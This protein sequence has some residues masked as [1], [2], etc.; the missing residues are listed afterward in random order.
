MDTPVVAA[1]IGAIATIAAAI[2]SAIALVR[3]AKASGTGGSDAVSPVAPASPLPRR[4][5]FFRGQAHR[6]LNF[7]GMHCRIEALD[8]SKSFLAPTNE[9][10]HDPAGRQRIT[11]DSIVER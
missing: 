5:V 4:M 7:G 9:L 10:F 3:R 2:I 11:R 1:L 6:F 8:G